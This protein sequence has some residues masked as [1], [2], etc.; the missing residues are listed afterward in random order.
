MQIYFRDDEPCE[1]NISYEELIAMWRCVQRG[2]AQVRVK[3][4]HG[5][6]RFMVDLIYLDTKRTFFNNEDIPQPPDTVPSPSSDD[7][8]RY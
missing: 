1:V 8:P 4:K 6:R 7:E 3:I 2:V 5:R